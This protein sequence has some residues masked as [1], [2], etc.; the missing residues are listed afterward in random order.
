[1]LFHCPLAFLVCVPRAARRAAVSLTPLSSSFFAPPC[2]RPPM[3][4]PEGEVVEVRPGV[5]SVTLSG[6]KYEVSNRYKIIKAIGHGAYG[7]VV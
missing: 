1:M 5:N 3:S 2:C 7:V 6:T 4:A